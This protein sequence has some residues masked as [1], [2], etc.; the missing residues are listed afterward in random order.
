MGA[1]K[2]TNRT[3]PRQRVD[4]SSRQKH[5]TLFLACALF[6]IALL[7]PLLC[8][9]HCQIGLALQQQHAHS[10]HSGGFFCDL[11]LEHAVGAQDQLH[12]NLP[13]APTPRVV[14]DAIQPTAL[15]V[16]LLSGISL[17]LVRLTERPRQK[18]ASPPLLPPPRYSF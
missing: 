12:S 17:G 14:H 11:A 8:I 7:N 5:P 1:L 15:L 18:L 6:T 10:E 16:V 2:L 13:Q 9:L 4:L 3:Q